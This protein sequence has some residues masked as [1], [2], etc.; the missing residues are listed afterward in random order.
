V[1]VFFV[2]SG[3]LIGGLI[4]DDLAAG[5]SRFC[6]STNAGCGASFRRWSWC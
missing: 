2:I 1:D 6:G 4:L 3:Y 5:A